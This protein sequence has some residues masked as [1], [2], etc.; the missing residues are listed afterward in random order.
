VVN[1]KENQPQQIKMD[2][3]QFIEEANRS[4]LFDEYRGIYGD[5]TKNSLKETGFVQNSYEPHDL[6]VLS[7]LLKYGIAPETSQNLPKT[8]RKNLQHL[9]LIKR[10]KDWQTV[11][12]WRKQLKIPI[13]GFKEIGQYKKWING[14]ASEYEIIGKNKKIITSKPCYVRYSSDIQKNSILEKEVS[15]KEMMEIAV[16]KITTN[17]KLSARYKNAVS[18][19]LFFNQIIEAN[20]GINLSIIEQGWDSEKIGIVSFEADTTKEEIRNS[21]KLSPNFK[22]IKKELSGKTH[23][24][25]KK[26]TETEKMIALYNE[27]ETEGAKDKEIYQKIKRKFHLKLSLSGIRKRIKGN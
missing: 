4:P 18:E 15:N 9:E 16:D 24:T 7:N 20:P 27:T 11:L 19:L 1:N 22:R 14:R 17:W 23:R 21:I 12:N 3:N 2:R 25:S 13:T 26:E 6:V 10:R 5:F 8:N